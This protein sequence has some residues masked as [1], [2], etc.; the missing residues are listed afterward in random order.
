M[1][2]FE[3]EPLSDVDLRF[4]PTEYVVWLMEFDREGRPH[5]VS[6]LQKVFGVSPEFAV[7]VIRSL[8]TM[9]KRTCSS[10]QAGRIAQA[11]REIG[12]DARSGPLFAGVPQS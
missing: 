4:E 11:L 6:N 2:M 10:S 12:G 1:S 9:V 8:P 7:R 3:T 5:A